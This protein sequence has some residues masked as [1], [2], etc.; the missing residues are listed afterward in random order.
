MIACFWTLQARLC[1]EV[2]CI[3]VLGKALWLS[4]VVVAKLVDERMG[5]GLKG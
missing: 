4:S 1:G 3:D 5:Y 2:R